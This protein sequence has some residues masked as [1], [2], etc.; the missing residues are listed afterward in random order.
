MLF[1]L[2]RKVPLLQ[3]EWKSDLVPDDYKIIFLAKLSSTCGTEV[4]VEVLCCIY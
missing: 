2:T 4:E 3:Y 1:N